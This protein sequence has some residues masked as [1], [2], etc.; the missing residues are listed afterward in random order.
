MVEKAE[1]QACEGCAFDRSVSG[2]HLGG[3][4]VVLRTREHSWLVDEPPSVGGD[5]LAPNP[6]DMLLA[7]LCSC[8]IITIRYFAA[9]DNMAVEKIWA[10]SQINRQGSGKDSRYHVRLAIKVSGRLGDDDLT[11]IGEYTNRCPVHGLLSK[12]AT[13]EAEVV[14]A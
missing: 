11:K 14:L 4:Q 5:G 6:F 2:K 7:S 1:G 9:R 3:Y 8:T 13:I 10:D 12:G